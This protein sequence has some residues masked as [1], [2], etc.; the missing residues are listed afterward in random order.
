MRYALWLALV[1]CSTSTSSTVQPLTNPTQIGAHPSVGRLTVTGPG[2]LEGCHFVLVA[3][4]WALTSAH[5][6]LG[7]QP[8]SATLEVAGIAVATSEVHFHPNTFNGETEWTTQVW[9]PEPAYDLALVHLPSSTGLTSAKLWRP[10]YPMTAL[11]A[12]QLITVTG[13]NGEFLETEEDAIGTVAF[14]HLADYTNGWVIE[15]DNAPSGLLGGDSGGGAFVTATA[16]PTPFESP[17]ARAPAAN[18]QEALIGINKTGGSLADIVPVYFPSVSSWINSFTDADLDNDHACDSVDNC[19]ISNPDQAN[20]NVTAEKAPAWGGEELGDACD[21]TPCAVP[22]LDETDFIAATSGF[23]KPGDGELITTHY[24]RSIRDKLELTPILADGSSTSSS[25]RVRFCICADATGAPLPLATCKQAPYYC[26]LDPDQLNNTETGGG[27]PPSATQTYWHRIT[28][29]TGY[30]ASVALAYPGATVSRTWNYQWDYQNWLAAGWASALPIDPK[31]GVGTDLGGWM[32]THDPTSNGFAAHG[33]DANPADVFAP[34]APDPRSTKTTKKKIPRYKPAPWWTYCAPCGDEWRMPG[35]E[36]I[37]P[38]LFLTFDAASLAAYGW[39]QHGGFDASAYIAEP[40]RRLLVMPSSLVVGAS[41]PLAVT[42]SHAVPRQ[43]VIAADGTRVLGGVARGSRA[44]ELAA[45]SGSGPTAR[46]GFAA[47]WSRTANA[48]FIVGGTDA[49][50]TPLADAWTWRPGAGFKRAALDRTYTPTNAEA[51][52][53]SPNDGRLWIVDRTRIGRRLIRLDPFTG[54]VETAGQLPLGADLESVYLVT[55][56]TGDVLLV[57]G[58]GA[59]HRVVRLAVE[60][61][62]PGAS[63]VAAAH[64]EG[65]GAPLGQPTVANGKLGLA[66]G[67]Q[68]GE[69]A[70]IESHVVAIP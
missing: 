65:T 10:A 59:R 66:V 44:F 54:I 11:A 68:L 16:V 1:G 22:S 49:S 21:P 63:V 2:H 3:P 8:F 32:W 64:R 56:G 58:I 29:N 55:T 41:E 50:G 9:S 61:F 70:W 31:Y 34:V 45:L 30:N 48:L 6:F 37:N 67:I 62:S 46:R 5:C 47:A 27:A 18:G 36:V 25:A 52:L 69:T 57:G 17:C 38:P 26:T 40:L 43:L 24:G 42:S 28:L 51:T 60:R 19:E 20:C 23:P 35:E 39:D 53:Y 12:N 15:A 33:G 13:S 14:L 7:I 4:R